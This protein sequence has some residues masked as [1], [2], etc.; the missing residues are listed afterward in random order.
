MTQVCKDFVVEIA[1]VVGC[2]SKGALCDGF[3]RVG[4]E[5]LE[6]VDG[7]DVKERRIALIHSV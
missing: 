3:E 5:V 7:A 6:H 4:V 2:W 1:N